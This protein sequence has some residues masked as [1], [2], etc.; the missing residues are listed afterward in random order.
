MVCIF[1]FY[2]EMDYLANNKSKNLFSTLLGFG[3]EDVRVRYDPSWMFR[4]SLGLY[5]VNECHV[6]FLI[7]DSLNEI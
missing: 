1:A 3:H 2:V 5:A 6:K 7:N 4:A